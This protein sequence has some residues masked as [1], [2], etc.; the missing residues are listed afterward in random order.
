MSKTIFTIA[1]LALTTLTDQN[2]NAQRYTFTRIADSTI[3]DFDPASTGAPSISDLGH[4]AFRTQSSDQSVT[5]VLRT[6]PGLMGPLVLIG[7]S[8]IDSEISSFSNNVSV[9]NNGQVAV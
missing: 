9:N 5:R 7:D 2:A 3:H 4:V 1:V 6:G 8:S